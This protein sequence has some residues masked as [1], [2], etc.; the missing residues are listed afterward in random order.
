MNKRNLATVL[1]FFMG[2]MV[3]SALAIT[4]GL[5]ALLGAQLAFPFAAFI[6]IGPGRR[7][8]QTDPPTARPAVAEFARG[9]LATE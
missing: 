4:I 8:W 9:Q 5:P 7:V 3:G 1:W 2:W 6:R